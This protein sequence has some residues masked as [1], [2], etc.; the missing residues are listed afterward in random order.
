MFT[1]HQ[2][3]LRRAAFSYATITLFALTFLLALIGPTLGGEMIIQLDRGWVMKTGDNP[4]WV[5]PGFDDGHWQTQIT[6]PEGVQRIGA[7]Y[8]SGTVDGAN[9]LALTVLDAD[10]LLESEITDTDCLKCLPPSQILVNVNTTL[11]RKPAR[12]MTGSCTNTPPKL[13][14]L[15]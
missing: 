6:L 11:N 8:L 15:W 7:D 3:R 5:K 9:A 4:E 13:P 14:Q 1:S 2:P 12:H 10:E